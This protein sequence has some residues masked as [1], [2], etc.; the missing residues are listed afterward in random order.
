MPYCLE[1]REENTHV[2][3]V[4][5]TTYKDQHFAAC[6]THLPQLSPSETISIDAVA[7]ADFDE[8]FF[9]LEDEVYSPI[10]RVHLPLKSEL[11]AYVSPDILKKHLPNVARAWMDRIARQSTADSDERRLQSLCGFFGD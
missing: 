1:C 9:R 8:K 5:W 7:R 2:V 11:I 6:R 3:C 4:Y 10:T